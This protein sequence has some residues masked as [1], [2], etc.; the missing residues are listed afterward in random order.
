MEVSSHA[1]DQDRI[2][3]VQFDAAVWTN[4]GSDHLDYHK[5]REQY[6][7]AKRKIFSSLRST[8]KAVINTDD[9][10]GALL[11]RELAVQWG[12]EERLVPYHPEV[13]DEAQ[14]EDVGRPVTGEI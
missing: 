9:P 8:G 3:G 14:A 11:L 10:E 4:L 2:D 7:Q 5:T 12:G 6:A 13:F 1:L